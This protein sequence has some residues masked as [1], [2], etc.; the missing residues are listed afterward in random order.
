M[1]DAHLHYARSHPEEAL[2][3]VLK[4]NGITAFALQCI[5]Q[6]DVKPVTPDAL[7]FKR[8]HPG[9]CFVLGELSRL[10]YLRFQDEPRALG[11]SLVSQAQKLLDAGCDGI[12]LLEGKPDIRRRFPIPDFDSAGWAPFWEF[13][14][15]EGVPLTLHLNDPPEFWV[16]SRMNPYAV[17]QGWFYG[18]D[19]V[20]NLEQYRQMDAVLARHPK[21]KLQLAHFYFH[22]D[23]LEGLAGMLETCPNL[24]LDLTPG[25]E[26]YYSLSANLDAARDFFERFSGRI[27][28]GTD[29]GS[30][31]AIACP[32]K[33]L[34]PL[35]SAPRVRLIRQFLQTKGPYTLEPDGRYLFNI[36]SRR[37]AGLD[38]PGDILQKIYE[39]NAW[40][41][42][43]KLPRPVPEGGPEELA[44]MFAHANENGL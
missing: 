44:A 28:F 6:E 39:A 9:R 11:G 38:L 3:K 24:R 2:E 29:I 31:A 33:A 19:T 36:P 35:E 25:V 21:L 12:K 18:E 17:Q 14:E 27:L 30:R 5:P 16:K 1:F 8:R 15:A 10:V 37:M 22:Y 26:I 23:Y 41:H 34:D 43:G 32:P 42:F 40:A 20:N 7:R 4:D 13:A